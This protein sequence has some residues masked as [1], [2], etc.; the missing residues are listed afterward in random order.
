MP[1]AKQLTIETVN[2]D[3][4]REVDEFDRQVI[5]AGMSR[6]ALKAKSC[7]RRVC[8]TRRA[9]P[10]SRNF[11][12]ISRRVPNATSVA[13]WP[14]HGCSSSPPATLLWKRRNSTSSG[15]YRP[16]PAAGIGPVEATLRRIH[17]NSFRNPPTAL[18]P[19]ES[20]IESVGVYDNSGFGE[21]P[22]LVL[23]TEQGRIVRMADHLP[24]WLQSALGR[25]PV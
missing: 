16:L 22:R 7:S 21:P 24:A 12:A 9:N 20:G 1:A 10:F 8:S 25:T 5:D 13:K 14:P 3:D 18:V 11:S 4:D 23:Q 15:C 2:L 17:P 6:S 19:A